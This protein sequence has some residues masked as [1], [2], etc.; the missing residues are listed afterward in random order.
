[1][2]F[3][4]TGHLKFVLS[5]LT[6]ARKMRRT[7]GQTRKICWPRGAQTEDAAVSDERKYDVYRENLNVHRDNIE[8]NISI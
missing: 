4:E 8:N 3:S 5:E 1:M 7:V 2:C 6:D